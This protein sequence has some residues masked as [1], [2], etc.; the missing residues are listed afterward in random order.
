VLSRRNS[1]RLVGPRAIERSKS[2][3][4]WTSILAGGAVCPSG[5]R[6]GD[7]IDALDAEESKGASGVLRLAT[8]ERAR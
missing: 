7:L 4:G 6:P 8:E 5:G 1:S 2:L 3:Q